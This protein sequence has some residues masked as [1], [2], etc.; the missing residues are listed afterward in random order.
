MAKG[1]KRV[2]IILGVLIVL[3]VIIFIAGTAGMDEVKNYRMPEI[4]MGRIA[5]GNYEGSCTISRWALKVKV[6]VKDY[7]IIEV[8]IVDRMSSNINDGLINQIDRNIIGK[9]SPGLD[10]VTGASITSKAY[11]IAI[12][13]ALQNGMK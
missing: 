4:D 10:A 7:K 2:L 8:D 1:V 13:D 11:L 12:A 6:T 9:A 5:D 3:G